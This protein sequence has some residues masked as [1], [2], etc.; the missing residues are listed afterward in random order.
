[1]ARKTRGKQADWQPMLR[2]L[3]LQPDGIADQIIKHRT[4]KYRDIYDA[5]KER[6]A[7]RGAESPPVS[8]TSLGSA[9]SIGEDAD[10]P[11][12]SGNAI[13]ASPHKIARVIT[14]KAFLADLLMEWKRLS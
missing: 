14:A 4:P 10:I 8:E 3:L 5:A 6:I 2:T 7:L 11:D 9:Q 12:E 1:M 13:G